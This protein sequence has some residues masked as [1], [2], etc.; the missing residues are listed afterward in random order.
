MKIIL[1][2][3]LVFSFL[4]AENFSNHFSHSEDE[5]TTKMPQKQN[6]N[7]IKIPTH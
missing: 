3:I 7:R 6:Q 4:K 5:N 1:L 2:A